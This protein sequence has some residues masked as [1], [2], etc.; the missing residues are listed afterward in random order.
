[1]L[2]I[3]IIIT[4]K[5]KTI[6]NQ[7]NINIYSSLTPSEIRKQIIAIN[8]CCYNYGKYIDAFKS[9]FVFIDKRITLK[10]NTETI[11]ITSK[12]DLE[13]DSKRKVFELSF[14]GLLSKNFNSSFSQE[15]SSI[16][17]RVKAE[18]IKIY[19]G[20]TASLINNPDKMPV[21]IVPFL[22]KLKQDMEIFRIKCVRDLSILQILIL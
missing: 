13:E 10:E 3:Y 22:Q 21:S 4:K 12:E 6:S 11:D 15:L 16:D 14:L 19:V 18:C 5:T 17:D 1:M 7:S 2:L 8:N 20:Q 9:T